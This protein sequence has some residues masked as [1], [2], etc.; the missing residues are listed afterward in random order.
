MVLVC[1]KLAV[2]GICPNYGNEVIYGVLYCTV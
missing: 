2:S 1:A